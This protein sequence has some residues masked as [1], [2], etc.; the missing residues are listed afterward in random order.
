M[1]RLRERWRCFFFRR[2]SPFDLGVC[3]ILFYGLALLHFARG[4][5][6]LWADVPDA[7]WWPTP[8][9]RL[10]RVPVLS[11]PWLELLDR[12]WWVALGLSAVG[13]FTRLGTAVAF[14]AGA[15]LLGLPQNF[16]KVHH[17]E[18]VV[19]FTLLVLAFS[20][21]GDGL[22][23]DAWLAR[24][25]SGAPRPASGEYT[26][27]VRAVWVLLMLV[28]FAAGVSKLRRSG[29]EWVF[30]P[31]LANLLLAHHYTAHAPPLELGLALARS[32]W[33]P[34]L[35]AAGALVLEL[36]APLALVGARPRA[37]IAPGL[38]L[39]QCGIWAL[40]GVPFHGF[41]ISF[42]FFVPWEA[43]ARR[44]GRAPRG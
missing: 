17:S 43:L 33:L 27:P 39:L 34:P 12:I 5:T 25:R 38:F 7:L 22:S 19:V 26:W 20:R 40:L 28:Y 9:F 36:A 14:L 18:T 23:I 42:L 32:A 41:L 11:A 35:L 15:Y 8:F 31:N 10:L 1:R 21:A 29:L 6:S 2:A 44:S 4:R 16:G 3:R 24:R 37:V 30:S 13:L